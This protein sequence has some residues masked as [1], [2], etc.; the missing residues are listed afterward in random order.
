MN[1]HNEDE[2]FNILYND[3]RSSTSSFSL[4]IMLECLSAEFEYISFH[5]YL[6]IV[7]LLKP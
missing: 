4:Y 5:I 1:A 2:A 7:F 6:L 3:G